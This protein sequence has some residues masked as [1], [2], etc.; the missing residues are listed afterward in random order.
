MLY[1]VNLERRNGIHIEKT[2]TTYTRNP[3]L[4]AAIDLAA[5]QFGKFRVGDTLL[6]KEVQE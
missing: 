2:E 5:K 1:Q 6:M 4:V 3:D